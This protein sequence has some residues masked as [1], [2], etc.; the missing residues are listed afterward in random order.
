MTPGQRLFLEV[1]GYV[2]L[3]NTL[4][5][6]EVQLTR[7]ALHELRRKFDASGDP[8]NHKIIGCYVG[9]WE[10]PLYHFSQSSSRASQ[11]KSKNLWQ[12]SHTGRGLSDTASSG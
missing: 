4:T 7:D 9:P 10:R 12:V 1:N 5:P 3:E 6:D 11:K 2:V 8:L